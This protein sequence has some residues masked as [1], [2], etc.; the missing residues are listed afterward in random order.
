MSGQTLA[1]SQTDQDHAIVAHSNG[2]WRERVPKRIRDEHGHPLAPD[3]DQA[4]GR[5]KINSDNHKRAVRGKSESGHRT[6]SEPNLT[7]QCLPALSAPHHNPERTARSSVGP[8]PR[9]QEPTRA[10]LP[11]TRWTT[12]CAWTLRHDVSAV[13]AGVASVRIGLED[14]VDAATHRLILFGANG[15]ASFAGIPRLELCR[16]SPLGRSQPRDRISRQR[17][18]RDG[19]RGP[20]GDAYDGHREHRLAIWP[21]GNKASDGVCGGENGN[22]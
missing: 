16:H 3:S 9:A 21:N 15:R 17:T 20:Y 7:S 5:S 4:I 11:R 12:A 22:D 1:R 8:L 18:C 10:P 2:R 13:G 6:D 19:E 14:A